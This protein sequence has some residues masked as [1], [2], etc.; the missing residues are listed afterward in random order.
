MEAYFLF[1]IVAGNVLGLVIYTGVAIL[2]CYRMF[3]TRQNAASETMSEGAA[4]AAH[5]Q[6][7]P[8]QEAERAEEQGDEASLRRRAGG[9][10]PRGTPIAQ[11]PVFTSQAGS[12][13]HLNGRRRSITQGSS[14][15]PKM[16][17]FCNNCSDGYLAFL[18]ED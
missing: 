2:M 13:V 12:R 15:Q 18:P 4:E 5:E 8:Q 6:A 11:I 7:V 9:E 10:R 14:R 17:T 1:K 3:V 16:W